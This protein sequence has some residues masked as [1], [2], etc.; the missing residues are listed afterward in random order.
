MNIDDCMKQVGVHGRK[1]A[2]II[3]GPPWPR[4][5]TAR[6]IQ[7]QIDFYRERGYFTVFVCVPLHCSYTESH[8]GWDDIRR[9]IE[10]LGADR[11]FFAAIDSRQFVTQKYLT[12]VSHFFRGTALDWVIFTAK[13]AR[14]PQDA[15]KFLRTLPV[16]LIHV[17]HIFTL[18]FA[19]HLQRKTVTANRVVPII[20]DTHDVQSNF[21][22]VRRELNPFTHRED[23]LEQLLRSEIGQ[24]R[25]ADVLVHV[26]AEDLEFFKERLPEKRHVLSMPTIGKAFVSEV[27]AEQTVPIAPVDL[28]FVGQSTLPN[29]EAIQWFFESVWP[30]I[31][32]C[33]Y[34]I[35]IIGAIAEL[36]RRDL[37]ELYRE[38]GQ[39][40]LGSVEELAPYYQAARCIIAPM[41]SGTGISIKTIEALALGKP[42]VGTSKAYRGMPMALIKEA[43]LC[44]HDAPEE[45]ADAIALALAE[46]KR[47]G[48]ISRTAYDRL[49]STEASFAAREEALRLAGCVYACQ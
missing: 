38:F 1:P 2:V 43:G 30:L 45:F 37:P 42:F 14:L 32:H 47:A 44:G 22:Y 41:I 26:S 35:R 3:T 11:N 12:W 23:P 4:S 28:L 48:S 16:E 36:I 33:R 13:S 24:L 49:F 29:A 8:P 39:Y 6:V 27:T 7:N 15:M 9:G 17:N 25:K 40:F 5:G 46:E 18:G 20:L 10:G 19:Q 21:F 34:Q 31:K